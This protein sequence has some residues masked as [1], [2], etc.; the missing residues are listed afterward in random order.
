MSKLHVRYVRKAIEDRFTDLIDM[1]DKAKVAEKDHVQAFLSRGLAA[2]AVQIEHPCSD[3]IAATRIF[4]GDDDRGLDAIAVEVRA[5]QPRICLV[6]AKWSDNLKGGFGETEVD[7]MFRGL[8]RMLDLQYS[9]FNSRFQQFVPEIEQAFEIGTPKITLVLALMRTAPLDEGTRE[10]IKEKLAE[11]NQVE[12]MVDYKVLD[13]R[14][15]H[16][17]ILGDA[18]APRIDARVRLD[19]FVQESTPYKALYGTMTAADLADLYSEHRRGLFARNIRD[20]LDLTDVN[21]KIRNTLLEEPEHFWYFSNGITM[22]CETIKPVG[23]AVPGKVGDFQLIGASVVNGA[24][25]VS[26]IHRAY[27]ADPDTA[28]YGRVMVR[29]ISLEDCP[30]GFGDHVTTN[31]NTQ[32]PIEERD[33]KSL[34]K[35]QV[36]LRDDFALML[37]LS[38][39]IKR[40][41]AVPPPEH[42]CS[43]AEAAEALAATNPN[44][45]LAALAKRDQNLAGLWEDKTYQEIFGPAPNAFRVWRSVE[46]LREVRAQLQNLRDGLLW[47]ADAAAF[48]GD[49]LVTHIVFRR[50]D[51][52]SIEDPT[53]H[54]PRELA[55]VPALVR[56]A[57]AWSLAAIDEEYGKSSHIIAAVRNTER[58]ERVVRAALRGLDSGSGAPALGEDYQVTEVETRGRQVNA[59]TTLIA[60]GRIA[61]G[62]VLEFRPYS[63]PERRDMAEWLAEDPRRSL[64]TWSNANG[65]QPL[66]WHADEGWY[67]PSGLAKEMRRLASGTTSSV[68]GTLRWF[69]PGEGSLDELALAV[70]LEEGLDVGDEPAGS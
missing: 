24:Q 64:A 70:R 23:K 68:Q 36:Q 40:G 19:G 20:N 13:L 46:L 69:V 63:K 47:R 42:G 28:Q 49:L 35:V 44:A 51:T 30:P 12:E 18:A 32:N 50:L 55:K 22:L 10:L 45:Q 2:L 48:Y 65:R 41:E 11:L 53:Y 39:V 60:N 21:I 57:L 43:M 37:H 62:T 56:D 8:N 5:P 9:K 38:Y 16:R 25:T 52:R 4:D 27:T 1:K 66:Q 14:D 3:R 7:R 33:F 29:L 58:I 61:D 67:S 31:T 6:Q 17:A 15:F 59:V 26:A 54:W 34:D